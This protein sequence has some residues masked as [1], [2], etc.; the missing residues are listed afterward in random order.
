MVEFVFW[1]MKVFLLTILKHSA[2]Q[3]I[4]ISIESGR[5]TSGWPI[6]QNSISQELIVIDFKFEAY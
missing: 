2:K 5:L 1:A 3:S 6:L 4:L